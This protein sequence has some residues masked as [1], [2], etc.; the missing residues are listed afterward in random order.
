MDLIFKNYKG[1]ICIKLTSPID[2]CPCGHIF[3]PAPLS[4]LVLSHITHLLHPHHRFW[5]WPHLLHP[6]LDLTSVGFP[7]LFL[8]PANVSPIISLMKHIKNITKESF[9]CCQ[10]T[11]YIF[12]KAESIFYSYFNSKRLFKS[13]LL[14]KV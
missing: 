13:V 3:S 12:S 10:H 11:L 7:T 5:G 1:G 2:W 6:R 8:P 9:H 4:S 14:D